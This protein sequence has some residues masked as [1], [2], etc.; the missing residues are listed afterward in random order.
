MLRPGGYG[1]AT[2]PHGVQEHDTIVCAHCNSIVRVKP[3]ERPEDIG[4]FC[5]ACA[6]PICPNC[7]GKDC[8]PTEKWMEMMERIENRR[9]MRCEGIL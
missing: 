4:G 2:G 6:K 8:I 5:R 9:R 1:I 3:F 7:V